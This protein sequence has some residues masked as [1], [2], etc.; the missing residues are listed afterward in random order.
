MKRRKV[1]LR[2]KEPSEFSFEERKIIV[3]EYLR[4]GCKKCVICTKYTGQQE[5]RSGLLH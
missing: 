4:T 1:I 2:L 5:E 3:E